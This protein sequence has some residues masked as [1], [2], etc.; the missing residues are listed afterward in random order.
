MT[1]YTCP[2]CNTPFEGVQVK[3]LTCDGVIVNV[4]SLDCQAKLESL[5]PE[6]QK[7]IV[8]ANKEKRNE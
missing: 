1:T 8:E 5:S 7:Q 6:E 4:C 3:A 2:V